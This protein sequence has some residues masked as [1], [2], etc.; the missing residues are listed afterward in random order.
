[1]KDNYTPEK[2]A[3]YNAVYRI[4]KKERMDE[5]KR[6][7]YQ[8]NKEKLKYEYML[9]KTKKLTADEKITAKTQHKGYCQRWYEKKK[10]TDPEYIIQKKEKV[11]QH[12]WAKKGIEAPEKQYRDYTKPKRPYNRRQ[13]K[14]KINT[15]L[16][17]PSLEMMVHLKNL[18]YTFEQIQKMDSYQALRIVAAAIEKRKKAT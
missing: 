12:Y 7:W 18:G 16:S 3:A 17:K 10:A 4:K 14:F 2:R 9:K 1:M 11:R 13:N 8:R 6:E 5:L 15:E